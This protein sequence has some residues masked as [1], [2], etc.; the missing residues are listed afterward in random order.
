MDLREKKTKRSIR[1]SFLQLRSHKP[2]ERITVTELADL[3]EISKATFY[4][5]YKD[6]YNL[7]DQLQNEVIHDILNGLMA[8]DATFFDI[9]KISQA[10]FN[11]FYA[12]HGLINI[13]FSGRQT[14]V[15]PISIE[16]DL[17]E[18]AYSLNPGLR[19]NV[20]FNVLLSSQIYGSYYAYSRNIK[21]FG[22]KR[23]IETLDEINEQLQIGKIL[24]D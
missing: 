16:Q 20:K 9:D 1:N 15:L 11:T 4:L 17:K 8:S 2:L 22:N 6:I 23:V 21:Q 14:D 18:Y 12:H 7:S 3:A 5:H 24:D 19:C 10:L 13:L